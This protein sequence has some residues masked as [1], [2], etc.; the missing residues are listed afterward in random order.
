MTCF[1]P[2][3]VSGIL[4][5]MLPGWWVP[6]LLGL[7]VPNLSLPSARLAVWSFAAVQTLR[8]AACAAH[9]LLPRAPGD[10]P[11]R[12][13]DALPHLRLPSFEALM[14]LLVWNC[15]NAS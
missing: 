2:P 12:G 3:P 10:R 5:A 4:T 13:S 7:L 11:A 14:L 9:G 8:A 6:E 1:F 15:K